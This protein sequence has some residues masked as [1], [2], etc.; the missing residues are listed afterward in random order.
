MVFAGPRPISRRVVVAWWLRSRHGAVA[1]WS[2]SGPA[3]VRLHFVP[4]SSASKGGPGCSPASTISAMS[5]FAALPCS[6]V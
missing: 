5:D 3:V 6:G 4:R 2:R 1:R